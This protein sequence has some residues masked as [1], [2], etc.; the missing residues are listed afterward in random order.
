[1]DMHEQLALLQERAMSDKNLRDE[2]LKTRQDKYPMH[3]FCEVCSRL[4]YDKITV[5]EL[6]SAGDTFCSAMLR[7]VNGGGV[8]APDGWNDFYEMFFDAIEDK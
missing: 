3:A 7:S 8:E 6:F 4:G 5:G 2:L 1:M